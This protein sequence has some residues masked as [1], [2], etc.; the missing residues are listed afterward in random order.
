MCHNLDPPALHMKNSNQVDPDRIVG[1]IDICKF[2]AETFFRKL[3]SSL[4]FVKSLS[5]PMSEI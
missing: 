2:I 1:K 3:R 4:A 5:D